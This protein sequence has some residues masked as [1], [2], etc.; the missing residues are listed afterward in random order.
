MSP[1]WYDDLEDR[2]CAVIIWVADWPA[3]DDLEGRPCAAMIWVADWPACDD[4]GGG[5]APADRVPSGRRCTA[6]NPSARC[7]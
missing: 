6:H 3:C 7:F 1:L 5:L 4:L 2:P